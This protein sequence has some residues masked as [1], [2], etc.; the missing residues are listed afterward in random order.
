M[1]DL[2]AEQG[3]AE[4]TY[5]GLRE[6]VG[7]GYGQGWA[8]HTGKL[9][10]FKKTI[11]PGVRVGDVY[12]FTTES[13]TEGAS[14]YTGGDKRPV[15]VGHTGRGRVDGDTFVSW[16][17]QDSACRA[18]QAGAKRARKESR[19]DLR[20]TLAPVAQMYGTLRGSA[21]RAAFLATVIEM[22]TRG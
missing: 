5:A 12:R 7:G 2:T 3:T 20:E 22:V 21:D 8:D 10:F 13:G 18:L 9:R 17:A 11:V 14:V 1:A 4:W 6:L 15:F 16:L 19:D